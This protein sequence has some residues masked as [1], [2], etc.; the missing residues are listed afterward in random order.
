MRNLRNK[1]VTKLKAG[2]LKEALSKVDD[3]SEIILGFYMKDKGVFF[4]YLAKIFTEMK[5]DSVIKNKLLESSV[6]ELVCF[7]DRYCTYM[8]R[9]D[10]IE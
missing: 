10:D 1:R 6:I 9:K 8:E 2:D 7:D 4:G 5:F 3:D